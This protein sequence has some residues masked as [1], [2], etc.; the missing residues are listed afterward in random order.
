MP[1]E[2]Q[3]GEA[4]YVLSE[5][6]ARIPQGREGGSP[7]RKTAGPDAG[8]DSFSDPTRLPPLYVYLLAFSLYL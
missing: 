3:P 5:V 1:S 4:A 2:L 8:A 6:R 7:G